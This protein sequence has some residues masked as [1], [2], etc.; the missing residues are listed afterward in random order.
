MR[1][2]RANEHGDS[3]PYNCPVCSKGF[4]L[5]WQLKRHLKHH[6]PKVRK[7]DHP[8]CTF[9]SDKWS[10]LRKH[11]TT[12]TKLECSTCFKKFSRFDYLRVHELAKHSSSAPSF[13][14]DL[15][16][17]SKAYPRE[18]SL[19]THQ[20]NSHGEPK[21]SCEQCGAKFRHKKSLNNHSSK[22]GKI[23]PTLPL[24]STVSPAK[25]KNSPVIKPNVKDKSLP[26]PKKTNSV[27]LLST[28]RKSRRRLDRVNLLFAKD[29]L[30]EADRLALQQADRLLE[31]QAPSTASILANNLVASVNSPNESTSVN[32]ISC[33]SPTQQQL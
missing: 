31:L 17:C 1:S 19:R 16:G 24:D 22:C 33:E 9:Q 13:A 28:A 29:L 12:H 5:Q 27:S 15:P 30:D 18:S 8:G 2:H 25:M 10:A 20:R 7:C 14:C 21:Y 32:L 11:L 3:L 6:R 26:Q 4:S 23:S